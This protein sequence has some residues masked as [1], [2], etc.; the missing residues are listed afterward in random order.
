MTSRPISVAFHIGAHKTATSH[1]QRSLKRARE[2][3]S[4]QGVQ[5]YGPDHFRVPGQSIQALFGSGPETGIE[6]TKKRATAQMQALCKDG[7]RLVMSEENFIGPLNQ[8]HGLAMKQRYTLASDRLAELSNAIG[9]D[10]DVFLAIRRPTAFI[11]SAYCQMLLGGRVQ[12]V[13]VFQKRNP[14]SSV[15]WIDL[16]ARLRSAHGVGGVT[17]WQYEDYGALFAQIMSALIG[18]DTAQLVTP[19]PRYINRGLSTAAVAHVLAQEGDAGGTK[20]AIAA[21]NMLPVEEGHSAFDGFAP[22]EHEIGDAA[23]ARQIRSIAQMQGVTLLR[24]DAG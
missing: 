13:E 20:A 2:A 1:L 5:Y 19:R 21:R 15:D 14:L 10:I 4:A 22:E 3:L 23:Y 24:P 18:P 11:N 7:H 17:V 9:Q 12:P 6:D 8:R 16:V